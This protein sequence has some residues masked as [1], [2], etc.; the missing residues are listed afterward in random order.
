MVK[1]IVCKQRRAHR[2]LNPGLR[3]IVVTWRA[4]DGK[5][6]EDVMKSGSEVG[7]EKTTA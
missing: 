7:S 6:P 4:D 5:G 1:E 2:Y 3:S